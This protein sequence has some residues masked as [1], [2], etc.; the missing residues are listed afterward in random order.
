MRGLQRF[1]REKVSPPRDELVRELL[2]LLPAPRSSAS[3]I[4]SEIRQALANTLRS[5][6]K[7]DRKRL[8]HQ[9][10]LD[11]EWWAE[12]ASSADSVVVGGAAAA[13][14]WSTAGAWR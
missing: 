1:C 10:S 9:A 4:T 7:I 2:K 6:Y 5:Y 13:R 11:L 12:R 3:A 14:M 8:A